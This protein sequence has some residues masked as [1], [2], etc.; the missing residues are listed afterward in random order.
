MKPMYCQYC[1]TSLNDGCDCLRELGEAIAQQR[2]DYINSPETH[3]GWANEDTIYNWRN[4]RQAIKNLVGGNHK[5]AT[6]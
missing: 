4:E 5:A 3:R 6:K 1:G 2:E